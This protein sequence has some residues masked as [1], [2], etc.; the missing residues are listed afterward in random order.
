[1]EKQTKKDR[2]LDTFDTAILTEQPI[3]IL[4]EINNTVEIQLNHTDNLQSKIE[5][6]L[7]VYDDELVNT[8]ASNV[9]I[10]DFFTDVKSELLKIAEKYL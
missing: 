2:L 8:K 9:K 3:M 10:I 5:Y 4:F 7:S 1:M 6:I